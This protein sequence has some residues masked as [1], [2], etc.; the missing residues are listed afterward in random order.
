MTVERS[1][2][3][4]A[5]RIS[6]PV[7]LQAMLQSSFSIVDQMMVGRLGTA[8]IAAVEVGAKPGFVFA[9][10]SGAVAT[11]TG[12][13]VSQ[14]LGRGEDDAAA[15]SMSINLC[16]M[17]LAAAVTS[18]MCL[19]M[20]GGLARLFTADAA[21][22]G[23]AAG[24]IR[25]TAMIFPLSGAASVLAVELRCR[26]HARYPLYI[27]AL[28]VLVNTAMNRVLIFGLGPVPALGVRGAA[29][30]SVASQA[31][32]FGL[33]AAAYRR[34]CV[35]RF[36]P[37]IGKAAFRQ[38]L[39]ML[40]PIV[41]NEFLW[42]VGQSV[43]TVIYG[44]M[45]TA[46]L[47]GMALTGPVQGLLIGALSGLSQAAGILIGQRLGRGEYDDAYRESL[48]LCAY[49]LAGSLALSALLL[50]LRDVYTGFFNVEPEVRAIG[51]RLLAVFAALAPVKVQNMILGGGVIR[52]GGRTRYIMVIDMMG[53]WLVGVPLG[54][55]TGVV[56]RLPIAWVYFI[57]SQE[58]LFRLILTARMFVSR[59]WMDTLE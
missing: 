28:S 13:M 25:L 5:M 10:V 27:S 36:D 54:L 52:S 18:L 55:L 46:E 1:F 9:F 15:G 57:L 19:L 48:R 34:V 17:A 32:N 59:K 35:L 44:H 45:G 6:V 53:T 24:Y 33:M 47:A 40:L 29:L 20:P 7:A 21:V 3:M 16:A 37:R 49:G 39:V 4:R 50:L 8:Q 31:V 42:T 14:Y 38:Y 22:A 12:I 11:V 56:W 41:L 58:E 26:D 30:A 51:S 43:N 2:F 23:E